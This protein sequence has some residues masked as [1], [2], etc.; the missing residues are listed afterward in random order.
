MRSETLSN[1]PVFYN[2]FK[3]DYLEIGFLKY[4]NKK[5]GYETSLK[6]YKIYKV[7]HLK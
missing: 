1:H 5:L 4:Q 3:N 6:E 7:F 2:D